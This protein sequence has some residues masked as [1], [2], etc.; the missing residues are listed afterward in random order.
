LSAFVGYQRTRDP[1]SPIV[2]FAPMLLYVYVYRPWTLIGS[3]TLELL[4]PDPDRLTVVHVLNLGAVL[5]FCVGC[6]WQRRSWGVPERGFAL[7]EKRVT[8]RTRHGILQVALVLGAV[9]C[10]VFWFLVWYSGGPLHVFSQSKPFLRSPI[11]SGYFSELT[12]LSFPALLLLAAAWQGKRLSLGRI[13]LMLVVG[14]PQLVMGTLG[15]RRGPAFLIACTLVACWCI[16]RSRR[17]NLRM[18][19]AGLGVIGLLLIML[20]GN[21][22]RLFRPWTE[23][24]DLTVV[25]KKLTGAE[26]DTGDEYVCGSAVVLA[27]LD[28]QNY[29]WGRR[30]LATF[31]VRAIPRQLWPTK[32]EDLGVGWMDDRPGSAGFSTSE[33]LE[34]VGFQAAAGSAGGFISDLFLEF[35][36]GAILG[37]F[38]IGRVYSGVWKRW[39]TRGGFWTLLYLEMVVFSVYLP[40]QSVG[41]W[42]YRLMLIGLPSWFIWYKVIKPGV[43]RRARTAPQPRSRA[44]P[45]E[46]AHSGRISLPRRGGSQKDAQPQNS[47]SGARRT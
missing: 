36:W 17:P 5:A 4:F 39:V 31:V 38:L 18:T 42:L 29:Y 12:I 3:G 47:G 26:A 10:G 46:V 2:I 25:N 19:L 9:S 24:V 23:D 28:R 20:G 13:L 40:S 30:Y 33:W 37:C 7:L 22:G 27:S 44:A 21:R 45:V 35:S 11:R 15:G 41:A 14:S 43:G 6:T 34:T 16:I 1:L 32:Y 8:P